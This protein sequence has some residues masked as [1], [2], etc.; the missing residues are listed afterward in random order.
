MPEQRP[1]SAQGW[2]ELG[3]RLEAIRER[4]I[5]AGFEFAWHNH[6]FEFEPL[7][8]GTLPM[9]CILEGGP[10]IKW[11]WMCHGWSKERKIPPSG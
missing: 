5:N 8:D 2:F 7:A 11:K 3:Q 4:T 9:T 10:N 1:D 6:H